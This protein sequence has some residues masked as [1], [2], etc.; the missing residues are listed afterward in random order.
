MDN[1][2][3]TM[4]KK[5]LVG[6]S[7]IVATV[8]TLLVTSSN[9]FAKSP[10]NQAPK[11]EDVVGFAATASLGVQA[12]DNILRLSG[13]E[14]DDIFVNINPE[15]LYVAPV[16]KHTFAARYSGEYRRYNDVDSLNYADHSIELIGRL[17]HSGNLASRFEYKRDDEVELPGIS[18]Q[19]TRVLD[20][21]NEVERQRI[22]A[23]I[24]YGKWSSSG[25]ARLSYTVSEEDFTNNFQDFRDRDFDTLRAIFYYRVS[26]KTR[27]LVEALDR[28]TEYTEDFTVNSDSDYRLYNVGADWR[29]T[30]KL[31]GVL[32]IGHQ[33][34]EFA[35]ASL[36]EI[37]GLA[38]F[39]DAYWEIN[40]YTTL[41][42]GAERTTRA[43][44]E[45]DSSG[46]SFVRTNYQINLKHKFTPRLHFEGDV[47]VGSD[48]IVFGG[49]RTDDRT[50][51]RARLQHDTT[52]A[53]DTY[54]GV[55]TF[56][57]SSNVAQYEFDNNL[58]SIGIT[59]RF[60]TGLN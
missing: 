11:I 5:G 1:L 13:N 42:V 32:K 41:Q 33:K 39:L 8:T 54:L 7:V 34:Q 2:I 43:S 45:I 46:G 35:T 55:E 56:S 30:A 6:S 50:Q 58:I 9:V 52:T 26:P 59:G 53:F 40:T 25:Q 20:E 36:D 38:F 44:A 49:G 3:R 37:S 17:E 51:F 27:F 10:L 57:R 23:E 18:N 60:G 24:I 47:Q 14:V 22:I 12:D 29:P 19:L 21:F 16:G 48:D 4:L 31:R 28:Q 15:L